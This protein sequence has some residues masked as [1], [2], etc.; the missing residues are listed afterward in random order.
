MSGAKDVA[1]VFEYLSLKT[2]GIPIEKTRLN[3]LLYFAQGHTLA[4]FN[5]ELF[6]NRIDAWEHG[7]VVAV[8][9]TGFDKIVDSTKQSG[10]TGIQLSPEDIDII[11]DVW[12]QYRIY[13][14]TELVNLTHE[15][16]TPWSMAYKPGVKNCNI[17][18]ELIKQY[19]SQP[20]N[21][22]KRVSLNFES[23]PTVSVFPSEDYDP[24]EDAIWEALLDD[25]K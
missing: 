8:V 20:K 10:I 23:V 13:S 1:R 3:K 4:E 7:P 24:A 22:L 9:F 12:E 2:D 18:N 16:D 14:A 17:P 25:A 15:D 5:R 11:M 19:F 6:S 21:R